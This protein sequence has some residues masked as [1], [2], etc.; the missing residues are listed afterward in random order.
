MGKLRFRSE[1]AEPGEG[2]DQL[3]HELAARYRVSDRTRPQEN[4][5]PTTAAKPDA[6]DGE[7]VF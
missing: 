3:G 7:P 5:S 1:I 4:P 6:P 2:D